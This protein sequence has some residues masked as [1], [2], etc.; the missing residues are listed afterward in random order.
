MVASGSRRAA[1]AAWANIG[2][3]RVE[4]IEAGIVDD[5]PHRVRVR[6]PTSVA[7]SR[8]FAEP[9]DHRSVEAERVD[10]RGDVVGQQRRRRC[11][12]LCTVAP[13]P[14]VSGAMTRKCSAR[15]GGAGCTRRVRR[16]RCG[17]VEI[18]A[19]VQEHERLAR[20]PSRRSGC[21]CRWR[22]RRRRHVR[23]CSG[24]W[25]CEAPSG[26]WMRHMLGEARP[27]GHGVIT[28]SSATGPVSRRRRGAGPCCMAKRLADDPVA[29]A[30]LRVDVLD[31]VAGGLRAR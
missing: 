24:W 10:Q 23:P 5:R 1:C 28:P 18:E 31:V 2:D 26:G 21:R 14:R 13:P 15:R 7:V 29:G 9:A 16:P 20:R 12:S 11:P 3:P 8:A 27:A 6:M 25:A 4:Q 19:A 22:A 17:P 30:D